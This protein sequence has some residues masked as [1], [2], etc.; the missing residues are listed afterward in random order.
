MCWGTAFR[1]RMYTP[2]NEQPF[3][4]SIYQLEGQ[5]GVNITENEEFISISKGKIEA[6]VRKYPWEVS[7]YLDG[8]LKTKEQIKDSNVDN[9][10]KNLP[11]GFTYDEIKRLLALMKQCIYMQMKNSTVSEKNLRIFVREDRLLIVGKQ[12]L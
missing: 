12:M 2:G 7:Y 9:M 4:N 5:N 8:K 6:R 11:V 1:F 10:C 3:D